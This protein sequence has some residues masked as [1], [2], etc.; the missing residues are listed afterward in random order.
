MPRYRVILRA[1]AHV[2]GGYRFPS[3]D[4]FVAE[5]DSL[6]DAERY[7]RVGGE[8]YVSLASRRLG[9]PARLAWH[10]CYRIEVHHA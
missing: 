7:G 3:R 5:F 8:S 1:G 10:E 2:D 4:C 9:L 6:D